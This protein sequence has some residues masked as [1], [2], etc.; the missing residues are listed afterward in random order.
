MILADTSIWVEFLKRKEP[1]FGQLKGLL[2]KGEI[3][4]TEWIFGEL[5]Q[6]AKNN[7]ESELILAYCANL[8]SAGFDGIWIEAGQ[9]SSKHRLHSKGIGLIDVSLMIAARKKEAKIWTW[10]KKFLA[11]LTKE[12]IYS[13]KYF[14]N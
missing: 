10:D 12:E 7:R 14:Y 11:V 1:V 4:T 8:P 9:Y 5:L 6:G 13:W 2:E 3:I